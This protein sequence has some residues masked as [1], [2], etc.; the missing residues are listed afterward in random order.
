MD[1][2]ECGYEPPRSIKCGECSFFRPGR[3]KDLSAP[4]YKELFLYVTYLE[5]QNIHAYEHAPDHKNAPNILLFAKHIYC[6]CTIDIVIIK[7]LINYYKFVYKTAIRPLTG[8]AH[9]P[10]K[11]NA[12]GR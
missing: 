10:G 8:T 1:C 4:L 7:F 3:A 6:G 11:E 9:F 12:E 5:I 2:C